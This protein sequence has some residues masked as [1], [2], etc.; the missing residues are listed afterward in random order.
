MILTEVEVWAEKA[1]REISAG[2][3]GFHMTPSS[4]ATRLVRLDGLFRSSPAIVLQSYTRISEDD[5]VD[6]AEDR[7][8]ELEAGRD[9]WWILPSADPVDMAFIIGAEIRATDALLRHVRPREAPSRADREYRLSKE[10][11]FVI[12]CRERRLGKA[13]RDR[14]SYER[15][16]LLNHRILPT[17]VQGFRVKLSG[18]GNVAMRA[19]VGPPQQTAAA[20]LFGDIKLAVSEP[21][22]GLFIVDGCQAAG[23]S[24]QIDR[25]LAEAQ[26]CQASLLVWPE[27]TMT[28]T[29]LERIRS[30]L[31]RRL[32]I[33][34][35]DGPSLDFVVAGSWHRQIKG[36]TVNRSEVLDGNGQRL[37]SFDK[38]FAYHDIDLGTEGI[39]PSR[40]L[41]VLILDDIL[42][43]FGIC[44]DFAESQAGNPFQTLD[45][46]LV[47]VPSMGNA[48]TV[49]GHELTGKLMK[50]R[51][52][53]RT[54]VVQQA[55][56]GSPE[57]RGFV[58]CNGLSKQ[59]VGEFG[60]YDLGT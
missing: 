52:T 56:P 31:A 28:P 35:A 18:G 19:P 39:A 36:H 60:L 46:D 42:V 15:R 44:R 57:Q 51:F 29:D 45:V 14:Q 11:A 43:A 7:R 30:W 16:G 1:A 3:F 13:G 20:G 41:Q 21:A 10:K 49:Q 34:D 6:A 53:T 25:N 38:L 33:D 22:G 5:L 27:L 9:G 2:R 58:V 54:F 4:L 48:R 12:P 8:G 50:E 59:Q 32:F 55:D 47:V 23:K 17:I 26:R 40:T 37:L 24:A